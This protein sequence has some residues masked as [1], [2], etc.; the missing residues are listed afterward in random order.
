[1]VLNYLFHKKE[2]KGE[3]R[4]F[5]YQYTEV[6]ISND[7]IYCSA[8]NKGRKDVYEKLGTTRTVNHNPRFSLSH[9]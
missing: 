1:M 5:E 9:D 8:C 6:L 3:S 7:W 4:K 2:E